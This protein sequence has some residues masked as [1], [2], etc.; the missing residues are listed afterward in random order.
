MAREQKKAVRRTT[1]ASLC[2]DFFL[3]GLQ[4]ASG[5]VDLPHA[6]AFRRRLLS[7]V[8]A[9][10]SRAHKAGYQP[11]DVDDA[12]YAIAAFLD[13]TIHYSSW[14]GKE[15]WAYNPLQAVLF[16][17]SR[18]G[19]NFFTRLDQV[20]KR[21]AAEVVEVYYCCLSL[22]F[23]GEYRLASPEQLKEVTHDVMRELVH[24][25][26]KKLS[27]R[28]TR[29]EGVRLGGRTLPTLP[30]AG[31]CLVVAALVILLLYFLL[32]SSQTDAIEL[33]QQLGR[34]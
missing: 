19:E 9:T 31:L 10:R 18:A 6:E 23:M 32:S 22:G 12:I 21:E 1:L 4:I 24:E 29:P 30:L 34:S 3:L 5:Q 2:T 28:G 25:R 11:T 8:D 14:G 33:L 27:P 17:E 15:E 16:G 7:L 20:C 26:P 13:E